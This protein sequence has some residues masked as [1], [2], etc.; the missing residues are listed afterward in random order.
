ME[1]TY[2]QTGGARLDLFNASW[3]FATLTA[4]REALQLACLGKSYTIPKKDIRGLSRYR[5]M[6]SVGLRIEHED[7][8]IPDF[9]V[10]WASVIWFDRGF[11]TLRFNLEKLGYTVGK[12]R[13]EHGEGGKASPATS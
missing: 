7:N 10:F 13:A 11:E 5:G 12:N 1:A 4:N 9:I 2:S 6:F 8:S 3:P